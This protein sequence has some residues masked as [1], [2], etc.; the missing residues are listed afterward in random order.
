M[1]LLKVYRTDQDLVVHTTDGYRVC[2]L[3]HSN[4]VDID[5]LESQC[6]LL[7][8]KEVKTI[9]FQHETYG[10]TYFYKISEVE[11]SNVEL[12]KTLIQQIPLGKA[13]KNHS[14]QKIF[15]PPGTGKTTFLL[16][17]VKEH[18][19]NG[20]Q[21]KNIA[22]ISYT[23]AA[24]NE[25]K[26]RVSEAF[27]GMGSVDFP[28]FSTMHSLATKIGGSKGKVLCLEEHW[29][30]FD[31]AIVCFTEWT[32]KNDPFS[33]MSRFRH[34]VLSL[35]SLVL[36]RESSLEK[37]LEKKIKSH[38]YYDSEDIDSIVETLSD[39]FGVVIKR[40]NFHQ[41]LDY[42]QRYID[43]Y[44]EFKRLEN[45]VDFNDVIV[46]TT[47]ESF[48]DNKIPSFEVLI[49]DEAQDLSDN[50]WTL[51]KKLIN[52]AGDVLIAGDDDQAIMI[53]FG[54]SAH[55]FL[56]IKTTKEDLPLPKS[57]RIPHQVM[58]Y[59]N[60]GVMQYI[61]ALPNRKPKV[62]DNADHEGTLGCMSDRH[63]KN[64]KDGTE[65][66]DFYEEFTINDLLRK[67]ILK[68]EEEWLILCPT[69]KT[70]TAVSNS[71]LAQ[72]PPIPHFYRN[73]PKPS[74]EQ[75]EIIKN[76]NLNEDDDDK[77]KKPQDSKIRIQTVHI[78][79]G[80]EADNVAIIVAGIAD[81]GLLVNDPRL[82]YVA[83]TRAKLN[84]YPRV[85]KKGLLSDLSDNSNYSLL[86]ST[87]MRMFPGQRK[88]K[89]KKVFF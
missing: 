70:G 19:A 75:I 29:K 8:G 46:N 21:P 66:K 51:A 78:S 68:K 20:V 4:F 41:I 7:I 25:A 85:V 67:V 54:A 48:D 89:G 80:D 45:L 77:D 84:L 30:K 14:S 79:K 53:N 42:C 18:V 33:V 71:L 55:E 9:A 6:K 50:L 3:R 59:V 65:Y 49:I 1:K 57:F 15:G 61:K 24:A 2:R 72:D 58:D 39:Y 12:K 28:N 81:I 64:K 35:Y 73:R 86:A 56:N 69:I 83:L 31:N 74:L 16:K 10:E 22:F 60:A 63:P 17:K 38:N 11:G 13:F 47:S 5:A 40:D 87:F 52:K 76:D 27:P 44:L 34:P 43:R 23:N 26:K 32:E 88:L 82:A 62:W 37:E 36:A